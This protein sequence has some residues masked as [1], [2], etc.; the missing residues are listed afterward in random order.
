MKRIN[1]KQMFSQDPPEEGATKEEVQA[2]ASTICEPLSAEEIQ[3]INA[4]QSNPFPASDPLHGKYK[5]FDPRKWQLPSQ[6]LPPSYL[7][8]LRWSNGG[9][10]ASGDRQFGFFSTATLREYLLSYNVPQYMPGALPFAFDGGG[11]FYLFDMRKE[12]VDGEYPILFVGAGNL[13]YED[14]VHVAD[15]FVDACK[16]TTDPA[17]EYMQ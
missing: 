7:D 5:P 8:F 11:C 10:V 16:G 6:P 9:E 2:L 14:A 4:S 15:S 17:D 13:G 1:W 3:Q 12:P